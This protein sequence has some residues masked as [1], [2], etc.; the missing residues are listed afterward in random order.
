MN[1]K[2]RTYSEEETRQMVLKE[3]VNIFPKLSTEADLLEEMFLEDDH[4]NP[5]ANAEAFG[6]PDMTIKEYFEAEMKN[7]QFGMTFFKGDKLEQTITKRYEKLSSQLDKVLKPE[8]FIN[9][10]LGNIMSLISITKR[11][12]RS[13]DIED[14]INFRMSDLENEVIKFNKYLKKIK[15]FEMEEYAL[16]KIFEI[17]DEL[18]K[19]GLPL[20]EL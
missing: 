3:L 8:R 5:N 2:E 13:R 15:G 7:L 9:Q 10:S 14:L 17:N 6:K 16:K 12:L 4:F 19:L 11:G 18:N 20:V 1:P